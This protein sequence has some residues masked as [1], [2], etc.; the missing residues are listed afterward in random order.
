M[1]VGTGSWHQQV[2]GG[3]SCARHCAGLLAHMNC[4]P[5][6]KVAC[7]NA[8]LSVWGFPQHSTGDL[9]HFCLS[10]QPSAASMQRTCLP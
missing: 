6:A 4:P 10:F 3:D 7:R 5:R 2:G 8:Q 1:V 9:Y